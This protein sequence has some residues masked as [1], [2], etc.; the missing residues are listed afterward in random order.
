MNEIVPV[1]AAPQSASDPRVAAPPRADERRTTRL[2][3]G[4]VVPAGR[5]A[6]HGA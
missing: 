5:V 4:E 3:V 2:D 1:I 6:H